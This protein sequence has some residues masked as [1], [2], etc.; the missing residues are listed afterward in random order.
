MEILK[1]SFRRHGLSYVLIKRNSHIAIYGVSGTYTDKILHYEV[2]NIRIRNDR[3]GLRESIP[4]DNEFGKAKPDCHF[5]NMDQAMLY[6]DEWTT[7]LLK[8]VEERDQEVI[9]CQ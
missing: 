1:K 6:F 3:Y 8:V 9:I 4:S 7:K 2:I 5:Q